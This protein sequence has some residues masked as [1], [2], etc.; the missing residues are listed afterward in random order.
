M[1]NRYYLPN[2][3]VR[4]VLDISKVKAGVHDQFTSYIKLKPSSAVSKAQKL[5]ATI[6]HSFKGQLYYLQRMNPRALL[7]VYTLLSCIVINSL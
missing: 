2:C 1:Y 6:K 4:P 3:Q 5:V 7:W